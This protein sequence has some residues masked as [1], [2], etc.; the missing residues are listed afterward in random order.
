MTRPSG[1]DVAS[2][3]GRARVQA[4][5]D[6]GLPARRLLGDVDLDLPLTA[7]VGRPEGEDHQPRLADRD[8]AV[9]GDGYPVAQAEG[10]HAAARVAEAE[11][12]G[13]PAGPVAGQVEP[14]GI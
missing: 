14:V 10:Q 4:E 2:R 8:P 12:G 3:P 13:V 5:L 9:R 1:D 7:A 11:Q 6:D